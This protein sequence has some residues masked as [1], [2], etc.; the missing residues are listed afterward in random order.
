MST[1][2]QMRYY[3]K[4]LDVYGSVSA[5]Q[6]L[7]LSLWYAAG[8]RQFTVCFAAVCISHGF[9]QYMIGKRSRPPEF[10][11][12]C[13]VMYRIYECLGCKKRCKDMPGYVPRGKGSLSFYEGS[14]DANYPGYRSPLCRNVMGPYSDPFDG[15]FD[16]QYQH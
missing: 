2:C 9:Q 14:G 12:Q 16:D 1:T 4:C 6:P 8:G 7:Q 5:M 3:R 11:E 13:Y 10:R 15:W